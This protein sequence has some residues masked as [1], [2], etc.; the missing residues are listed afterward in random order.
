MK[1]NK[2]NIWRHAPPED[3][4]GR[5]DWNVASNPLLNCPD[6]IICSGS[7]W[8]CTECAT[9]GYCQYE[10]GIKEMIDFIKTHRECQTLKK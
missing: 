6:H 9:P 7:M 3:M 5:D 10:H 8:W 1:K 4:K 2:I